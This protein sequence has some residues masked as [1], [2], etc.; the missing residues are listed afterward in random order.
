MDAFPQVLISVL[1]LSVD[2]FYF[3]LFFIFLSLPGRLKAAPRRLSLLPQTL[4]SRIFSFPP[5]SDRVLLPEI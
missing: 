2:S 4:L 5:L 3:F 1:T